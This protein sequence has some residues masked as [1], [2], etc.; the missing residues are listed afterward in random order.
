MEKIKSYQEL[1][2]HV[3][4]EKAL[5]VLDCSRSALYNLFDRGHLRKKY[6]ADLRKPYVEIEQL[7]AGFLVK[8]SDTDQNKKPKN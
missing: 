1:I 5:E 8:S 4:V 3:S 2:G 7:K 6:F